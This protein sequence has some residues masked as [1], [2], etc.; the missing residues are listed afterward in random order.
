MKKT[1][2]RI[3]LL[4]LICALYACTGNTAPEEPEEPIDGGTV[5][6]SDPEAPKEIRSTMIR[7][8]STEFCVNDAWSGDLSWYSYELKVEDGKLIL[9]ENKTYKLSTEADGTL[10]RDIQKLIEKYEL[11]QRNGSHSVTSGLPWEYAP[12]TLQALYDGGELLTF[13]EDNDPDAEWA[14]ELKGLFDDVFIRAGLL[15]APQE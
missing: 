4:L 3:L 10:R 6:N 13:T 15:E 1:T 7:E 9:S 8:F 12:C 2:R 14:I 5:D 11:V